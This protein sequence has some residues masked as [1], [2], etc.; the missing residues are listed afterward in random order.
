VYAL[1][2]ANGNLLW[3]Q[4]TDGFVRSSA[5]VST[6]GLLIIGSDDTDAYG[7]KQSTGDIVWMF[8]TGDVVRSKAVWG[9][10]V[11][12]IASND[13]N[14]YAISDYVPPPQ[15]V[16]AIVALFVV[17]AVFIVGAVF[18]IRQQNASQYARR[19]SRVSF[20]CVFRLHGMK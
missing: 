19:I 10:N 4:V 11:A 7:L 13:Q 16:G 20:V 8:M 15:P 17:A 1:S 5:A 9:M 3:K 6:N 2:V 12:L 18:V 14:V